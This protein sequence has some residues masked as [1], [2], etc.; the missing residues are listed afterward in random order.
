[1]ADK[2]KSFEEARALFEGAIKG[3]AEVTSAPTVEVPLDAE[4]EL[5]ESIY[6]WEDGDEAIYIQDEQGRTIQILSAKVVEQGGGAGDEAPETEVAEEIAEEE[7][8][9]EEVVEEVV[10]EAAPAEEEVVVDEL[11]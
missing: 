2:A 9:A 4:P 11:V 6:T 7:A 3:G 5:E 10:E 1:M 8:P